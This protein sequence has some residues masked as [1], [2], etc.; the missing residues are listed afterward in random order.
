LF[1][2]W[3]TKTIQQELNQDWRQ[4]VLERDNPRSTHATIRQIGA[5]CAFVPPSTNPLMILQGVLSPETFL[6]GQLVR[7]TS[8]P[9]ILA[10]TAREDARHALRWLSLALYMRIGSE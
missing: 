5:L 1:Y 6:F 2:H 8:M 9:S 4:G 7:V 3:Q 10:S